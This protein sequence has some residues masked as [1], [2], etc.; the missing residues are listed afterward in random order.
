MVKARRRVGENREEGTQ[1][2]KKRKMQKVVA[3]HA[4]Q[5]SRQWTQKKNKNSVSRSVG[6]VWEGQPSKGKVKFQRKVGMERKQLRKEIDNQNV[7]QLIEKSR[8]GSI[9]SAVGAGM[10]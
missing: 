4:E 5:K 10:F 1:S 6:T 3:S 9:V 7:Q 2:E 8:D